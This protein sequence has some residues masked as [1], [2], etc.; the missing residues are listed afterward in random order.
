MSK[1]V[2]SNAKPIHYIKEEMIVSEQIGTVVLMGRPTKY[3]LEYCQM[4]I[5]HMTSGY[6]FESFAG[7]ISVNRDTLYHW[8]K[9]FKDFSDSKGIARQKQLLHDEKLLKELTLGV[10]GRSA[11]AISHIYKMKC[12]HQGWIEKQVVEQTNK[13][14]QINIDSD[15]SKL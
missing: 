14:I 5:D 10:H 7:V 15:D 8:E 9:L 12:S 13:N 1:G 3:K 2:K 11:N 4:L 6:S